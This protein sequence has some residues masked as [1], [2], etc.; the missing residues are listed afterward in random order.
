MN[1]IY[2]C[3]KCGADLRD[4]MIATN[5]PINKKE[6]FNC[7]WSSEEE[8]ED[9]VRIPYVNNIKVYDYTPAACRYCSNHP[10]NGGS[11]VCHCILGNNTI[12]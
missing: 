2:T 7:G 10:N 11:G 3:P 9:V 12:Y 8:R 6:C 5:P 4:V 1:I